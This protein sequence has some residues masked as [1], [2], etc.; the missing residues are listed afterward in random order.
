MYI[1]REIVY[2]A[3]ILDCIFR[4]LKKYNIFYLFRVIIAA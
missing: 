1:K 3:V 4:W 2:I